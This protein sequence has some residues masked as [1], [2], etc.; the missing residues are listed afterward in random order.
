MEGADLGVLERCGLLSLLCFKDALMGGSRTQSVLLNVLLLHGYCFLVLQGV[1]P[2][3]FGLITFP[4]IERH[5]PRTPSSITPFPTA[6]GSIKHKTPAKCLRPPTVKKTN[7]MKMKK[8]TSLIYCN[9]FQYRG[10]T[11]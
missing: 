4:L 7:Q 1:F 5:P 8:L 11:F 9:F 6:Q 3:A 10:G 2:V